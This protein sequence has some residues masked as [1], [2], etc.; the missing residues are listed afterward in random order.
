VIREQPGLV[1]A[2]VGA[3]LRGLE[4]T[5]KDPNAAFAISLR[6]VPEAGGTN[7]KVSRAIFDESIKL[8]QADAATLGRADPE[9][10]SKAAAFMKQA[11]LIQSDVVASELY[12]N[13]FVR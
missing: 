13:E 5:L 8:W 3:T 7:E 6:A 1:R 12:T 11:G 9:A 2:L 10:W 4:D